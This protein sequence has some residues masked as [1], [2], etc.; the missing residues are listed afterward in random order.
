MKLSENIKSSYKETIDAQDQLHEENPSKKKIKT[1]IKRGGDEQKFS[2]KKIKR[3]IKEAFK[4]VGAE[5]PNNLFRRFSYYLS[6]FEDKVESDRINVEDIQDVVEYFLMKENQQVAKQYII[7]R[8]RHRNIREFVNKKKAWIEN[9]KGSSNTANATIDDNSNVTGKNVGIINAEIH[10]EDNIQISRGMVMSKLKELFPD[11]DPK[12]YIRDIESHVIYKHDES[13]F[14]GAIAPYCVSISMFPFLLNGLKDLGGLSAAPHNLDSYC[15]LY[16]NLIF[17]I[18]GQF[19]GAVATSE[20][21]L[22]F[23]YFARKQ[24]G[25]EYY[26]VNDEFVEIGH[27]LRR[28]EKRIQYSKPIKSID[29]IEYIANN[30]RSED[31]A[32]TYAQEARDLAKELLDSYKDGKLRDNTRTIK[33]VIHQKFQQVV[34]S[35]NQPAAAR[36]MQAAFVNFS[37]F[38]KPYFD[39]MFGKKTTFCFPDMSTPVWDSLNWL[40]KD[41]MMWFNEERLHTMI[42]FPVESFALIYKNGKFEDEE[43]ARFV[44]EEYARGHSFFVYISD[45][46]DSLASCCF[47]GDEVIKVSFINE[48]GENEESYMTIKD[49]VNYQNDEINKNG[50]TDLKQDTFIEGYS[51]NGDVQKNIKITGVLKKEYT[52]DMYELNT[53]NSSICITADHLVLVKDLSDNQIKQ[54]NIEEIYKDKERYLVATN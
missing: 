20:F 46:A 32:V 43:N 14:A 21:L 35:I 12:N 45:T 31:G 13:S 53:D 23:D 5:I 44:A 22:Y 1:V 25:Q 7:Y 38:D 49:F 47:D 30:E 18:A 33:S 50:N 26:K 37:Y 41:F 42:T 52:G 28:L 36:G 51:P 19:A 40:Q 6:K 11:F 27:E 10:K 8:E 9:Y 17:A 34:Y 16:I 48:Q 24:F 4:S 3:A 29:D 54:I 2:S 15:G 39:S